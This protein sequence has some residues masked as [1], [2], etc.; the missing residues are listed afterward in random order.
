MIGPERLKELEPHAR[1]VPGSTPENMR[2][3]ECYSLSH[4]PCL[5]TRDAAKHMV[6]MIIAPNR[7][8]NLN[9]V[10][11]PKLLPVEV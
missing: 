2:G 4:F 3:A 8:K 7:P 9:A 11:A 10:R 5:C 1:G 6:N